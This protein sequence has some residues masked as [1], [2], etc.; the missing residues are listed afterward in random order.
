MAE[1]PELDLQELMEQLLHRIQIVQFPA[2]SKCLS[3][4]GTAWV[5]LS[6]WGIT[7]A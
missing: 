6:L 3:R 4:E 2:G 7:V 1:L 5:G